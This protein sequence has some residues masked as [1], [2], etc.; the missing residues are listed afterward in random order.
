MTP[1][2]AGILLVLALA[3]TAGCTQRDAG[4]AQITLQ[5]FFGACEAQYGGSTDVAA[6]EGE[7]GII[8]TLVNQFNAENPDVHVKTNVVYWPG[9]DQL[10]AALAAGEPPDLVT[11]HQSVISD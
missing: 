11:L 7:C 5:R 4:V 8:T 6:A 9:Y 10:S 1:G 3:A 2:K